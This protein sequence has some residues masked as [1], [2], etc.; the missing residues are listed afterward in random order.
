MWNKDNSKAK[1]AKYI[2]CDKSFHLARQLY[3]YVYMYKCIHIYI[4]KTILNIISLQSYTKVCLRK[5]IST[6]FVITIYQQ[7]IH[8]FTQ[9]MHVIIYIILWLKIHLFSRCIHT[10]QGFIFV[11]TLIAIWYVFMNY[12]SCL[13]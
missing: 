7:C 12:I 3:I 8:A 5:S 4:H 1:L 6:R 13:H 2:F 10:A 9:T 11:C